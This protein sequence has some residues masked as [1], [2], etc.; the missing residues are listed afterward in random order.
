MKYRVG[1]IVIHNFR[2]QP[3]KVR[4]IKFI[5]ISDLGTHIIPENSEHYKSEWW[6]VEN[7][8]TNEV[9]NQLSS[10]YFVSLIKRD[11]SHKS[12]FPEWF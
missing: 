12:H 3:E 11:R 6:D 5:K 1:D 9:I 4:L 2:N 7:I 8:Y 10:G